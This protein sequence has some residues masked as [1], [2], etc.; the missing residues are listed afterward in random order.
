MVIHLPPSL[1]LEEGVFFLIKIKK[2]TNDMLNT[3]NNE[4]NEGFID[5]K[6]SPNNYNSFDELKIML[7]RIKNNSQEFMG[8]KCG[9]ING[10]DYIYKN[11]DHF[12]AKEYFLFRNDRHILFINQK[13]NSKKVRNICII[14]NPTLEEISLESLNKY[15]V[16]E[17]EYESFIDSI[18]TK[19]IESVHSMVNIK[20]KL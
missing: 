12:Y 2:T 5:G 18:E 1:C 19:T 4:V 9:H 7:E 11:T 16:S 17:N 15:Y 14:K 13:P 8:V 3:L 6:F 20:I 10:Y